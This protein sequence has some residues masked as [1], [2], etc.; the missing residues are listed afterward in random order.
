M[1][2]SSSIR[3]H[4]LEVL[5]LDLAALEAGELVEAELEDGVGLALG[6]RV[7]RHQALLGLVA[8]GEARMIG[9]SRRGYRGR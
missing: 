4:E 8:V 2:R 6:E 5:G 9:R 3:L 7:L 1:L